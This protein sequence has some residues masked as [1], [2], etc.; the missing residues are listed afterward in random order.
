MDLKEIGINTGNW[1]DSSQDS[2]YQIALVNATVN[3]RVSY[4]KK[5][6]KS[7]NLNR[8]QIINPCINKDLGNKI[9]REIKIILQIAKQM[10]CK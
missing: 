10:L 1:V 8:T 4:I 3:L 2:D 5:N 6:I 7:N 9:T